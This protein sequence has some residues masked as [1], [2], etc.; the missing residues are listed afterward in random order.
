M[1]TEEIIKYVILG[2]FGYTVVFG[3]LLG[4]LQRMVYSIRCLF[5]EKYLDSPQFG[6]ITYVC[7]NIG[8]GKTTLAAAISN[9]LAKIKHDRAQKKLDEVRLT[10]RDL[11]FNPIDRVIEEAYRA[12]TVDTDKFVDEL[13]RQIPTLGDY[14]K[15]RFHYAGLYPIPYRT[16]VNDY[17]EAYVSMLRDNYVYFTMGKFY[18]WYSDAWAMKYFPE[19]IDIKDRYLESDYSIDRYTVMFEDEKTVSDKVS[20]NFTT[21]AKEDGG[22]DI[23]LRLLRQIGKGTIHYLSTAQDFERVVKQERELATG[24]LYVSDRKEIELFSF[25]ETFLYLVNMLIKGWSK[26]LEE[27]VTLI[28]ADRANRAMKKLELA[29][30]FKLLPPEKYRRIIA[31]KD[32]DFS[33][34]TSPIRSVLS[35]L[36]RHFQMVFASSFIRYR[37]NYYTTASDVGKEKENCIG[38]VLE[39]DLC[40]PISFAY[41]STDTFGFATINDFLI[42]NSVE[43]AKVVKVDERYIPEEK[44]REIQEYLETIIAKR[45]SKKSVVETSPKSAGDSGLF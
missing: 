45:K 42:S 7:G 34:E 28:R 29:G 37:G 22:G 11:D 27:Y 21:V 31:R 25:V 23:F 8:V 44:Q 33:K 40:F 15:D 24:I 43:K 30:K 36:D 6:L 38:S 14:I 5:T 4:P 20:T 12:G 35:R 17:V 9:M 39:L 18:S 32:V 3:M 13:I 1:S 19:M 10:F 41:G 16:M 2:A 26:L